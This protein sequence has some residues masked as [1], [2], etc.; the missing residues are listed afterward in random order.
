LF[1]HPEG[2]RHRLLPTCLIL[3]FFKLHEQ[4]PRRGLS[5]IPRALPQQRD[6]FHSGTYLGRGAQN[7]NEW[8][9]LA[10]FCIARPHHPGKIAYSARWRWFAWSED[11]FLPPLT[12]VAQEVRAVRQVNNASGEHFMP[13]WRSN[14]IASASL[15][16]L[17]LLNATQITHHASRFTFP[18]P[19]FLET[20]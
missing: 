12:A 7:G 6:L 15:G 10:K 4:T 8:A 17:C 1:G 18:L 2:L 11:G 13:N 3:P 20:C 14:G 16:G 5:L 19:H 9:T